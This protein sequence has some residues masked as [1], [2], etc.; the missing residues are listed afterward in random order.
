MTIGSNLTSGSLTI[1]GSSGHTGAINLGSAQT[2][3]ALNLGNGARTG[4]GAINMG[5]QATGTIAI[6]I[7]TAGQTTT[8][9]KGTSVDV[10]TKLTSPA[11]EPTSVSTAL[12]IGATQTSG[13]LNIGTGARLTG[14]TINIGTAVTAL[15]TVGINVGTP[16]TTFTRLYG[17][18]VGIETKMTSPVIDSP[19]DSTNMTL[20]GN[21]LGG[22]LTIGL[23]Q[24]DGIINIG[25]GNARTTFGDI[26]IGTGSANANT[27]TIGSSA[28]DTVLNGTSVKATTKLITPIIDCVTD[29]SAGN[30][31]LSIGPSA[32]NGNILIGAQLGVGDIT[33]GGAQIAGGTITL[34]ATNTVTTLNGTSVKATTKLITPIIDCVTDAGAGNTSLSIGPSAINGNILIG[35]QLGVGDITI[36]GAQIAGGTI[37]LGSA[38]TATTS[39]GTLTSTGLLTASSGITTSGAIT[40]P[41]TAYTPITSQ[42]GLTTAIASNASI[43]TLGA[44]A[45]TVLTVSSIPIGVYIVVF[46]IRVDGQSIST[47]YQQASATATNGTLTMSFPPMASSGDGASSSSKATGGSYTGFF[48]STTSAGSIVFSALA[49]DGTSQ[50]QAGFATFTSMRIA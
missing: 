5:T 20:G 40:L 27:V 50:V 4:T 38:S 41:A 13:I 25:T 39:A 36:G 12:A 23:A 49:K 26:N 43:I 8:S 3:G 1:G 47:S 28:S 15:N 6:T 29:A 2:T 16:T 48:R 42:L 30:T 46:T 32:V 11:I 33:I 37:T 22:N 17:S 44:T 10:G 7:G 34:G 31:S 21:L 45:T 9:L 24:T 35:A 14:G 18:N 19:L